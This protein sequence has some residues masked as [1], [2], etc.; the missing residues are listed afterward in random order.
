[1]SVS[2][3]C[4][5]LTTVTSGTL[6]SVRNVRIS[7]VLSVVSFFTNG[8]LNWLLIFGNLGAPKLG[9]QGAAIATTVAR[10][11]EL[12]LMLFYMKYKE[13]KLRLRI[14]KL[15]R[16]DRSITRNYFTNTVPVIINEL[17]WSVGISVLAV[18]MGRMGTQFVAAN[19][20]F[21]VTS[22]IAG[23]FGQGIS[24]SAA[25][26][27]GNAIGAGDNGY[28]MKLK[29][30]FQVIG[31]CAG[32]FTSLLILVM[33]P[34]MLSLYNVSETTMLY[35]NQI[36]YAGALVQMFKTAQSLNMFG[37][38]R[39]GGDAKFVMVNDIVFL[40]MLAVPLGYMAGLVWHLPVPAVYCIL[41]IEQ[42]IKLFTS[43]WRLRNDK[44]IKNVTVP[45]QGKLIAGEV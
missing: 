31:L 35:A 38:L 37:I 43:S 6:R 29:K 45:K 17:F 39:G 11:I 13:D 3:L 12:A 40:W 41:N 22:Q 1:V 4:Y 16:I 25:V 19:S 5:T 10:I 24:A 18:I 27:I 32:V 14:R 15:L 9:I 36:M 2:Y 42:F 23:V 26:L 21:S 28:T 44:W 8:I 20:I 30:Q 34:L 33:R 7:V